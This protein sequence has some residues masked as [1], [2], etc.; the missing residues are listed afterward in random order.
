SEEMLHLDSDIEGE[1]F[2]SGDDVVGTDRDE[3]GKEKKLCESVNTLLPL[4]SSSSLLGFLSE[5]RN[6]PQFR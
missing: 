3:L 6:F 1:E 2:T 5:S 4:W